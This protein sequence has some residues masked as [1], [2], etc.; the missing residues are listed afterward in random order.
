MLK[1]LV[2]CSFYFRGR[3]FQKHAKMIKIYSSEMEYGRPNCQFADA[4]TESLTDL[5]K[6][7]FIIEQ[8]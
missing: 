4:V 8:I 3:P 6:F 7:C 1:V 2:L 5:S